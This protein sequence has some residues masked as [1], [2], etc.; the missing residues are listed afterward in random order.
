MSF[1]RR[2]WGGIGPVFFAERLEAFDAGVG[3]AAV[4]DGGIDAGEDFLVA[5][6]VGGDEE[7]VFGLGGMEM[8]GECGEEE[9]ESSRHGREV[10][11]VTS[12]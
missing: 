3:F 6:A 9:K 10:R 2:S 5:K 7:D 12:E 8:E 4:E 11:E 1:S